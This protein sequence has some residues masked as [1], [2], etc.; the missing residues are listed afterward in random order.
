MAGRPDRSKSDRTAPSVT[1][2]PEVSGTRSSTAIRRRPASDAA[3][4]CRDFATLQGALRLAEPDLLALLRRRLPADV[5]TAAT[6]S[7][8]H[9]D[10]LYRFARLARA[11]DLGHPQLA[12]VEQLIPDLSGAGTPATRLGALEDVVR[13]TRRLDA[14]TDDPN[15]LLDLLDPALAAD[16]ADRATALLTDIHTQLRSDERLWLTPGALTRIEGVTT[17]AARAIITHLT[18]RPDPWLNPALSTPGPAP[19]PRST[20]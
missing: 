11:V 17:E 13:L 20:C 18:D 10:E 4:P 16:A 2:G 5:L 14:V 8:D 7:A 6:L 15:G 1:T 19:T 12:I 3:S 9:L